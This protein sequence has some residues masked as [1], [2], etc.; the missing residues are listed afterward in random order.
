MYFDENIKLLYGKAPLI[1]EIAI[2]KGFAEEILKDFNG[3]YKNINE[4]I[5]IAL[6]L[7][8]SSNEGS[9]KVSGIVDNDYKMNYLNKKDYINLLI[10]DY[11]PS[12]TYFRSYDVEKKYNSYEVIL[13]RDL[14]D[15][16]R[17]TRNILI[18]DNFEDY[19]NIIGTEIE[20]G[21]VVGV[22]K[23]KDIEAKHSDSFKGSLPST[24][25]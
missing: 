16:D 7:N 3:Y 4:L 20:Y 2:S 11:Y 15:E 1:G 25:L 22:F 17:N 21:N 8:T 18:S 24:N 6:N 13:G 19:E 12:K 14:T 23:L 9:L 5:G 10:G